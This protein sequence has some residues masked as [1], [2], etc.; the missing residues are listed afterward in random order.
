[1][2][3]LYVKFSDPSYISFGDIVQKNKRQTAVK[4]LLHGWRRCGYVTSCSL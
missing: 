1:V 3:H 4:S 2:E